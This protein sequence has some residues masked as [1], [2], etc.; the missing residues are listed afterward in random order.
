MYSS[1]QSSGN[2]GYLSS[3]NPSSALP[4]PPAAYS[5]VN[6]TSSSYFTSASSS[7]IPPPPPTQ[8]LPSSAP[9]SL[10]H[11]LLHSNQQ[12]TSLSSSSEQYH[13]SRSASGASSQRPRRTSEGVGFR[14]ITRGASDLRPVVN[15]VPPERRL[16]P[17]NGGSISPL[18]ALTTHL[19][20]TYRLINPN[21][22]YELSLNPRRVLTKPSRPAGNNGM[23]NEDSDYILYVNDILGGGS[24][25]DSNED[26]ADTQGRKGT[27]GHKYLI[28][29]VL[30]QGTFGQVVK[31]QDMKNHEV[32]AVK[33][34]KNKQAYFSQ[35]MM[36]VTILELL[37]NTWDPDNKHHILR[38]KDTFIHHNH[39]CLVFELLSSNLY[40]LIKQNSFRGLSTSLVRV[41]TN[42]L[43]DALTVL[44][45]ARLIHCD[46]KPENILLNSLSSPEIKVIDFGSACHERQTVYTYIQSRF[47]RSPEVI[48]GLPYSSAIDM[49]SLGCICVELFLGLPLFPGTSEFNQ[50]TRIVEMLGMP[51]TYMLEVGKQTLQFF[52][53]LEDDF[54]GGKVYKLKSL[55]QYSKEHNVNE[56]PS[57]RYFQQ[58][59]LEDI[60]SQYPVMR[61]GMKSADLEKEKHNRIAFIDF[62]KGL[63]HLN[64]HQRWTPQQARLHPFIQGEPLREP[65]VP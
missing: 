28:L 14:R 44:N 24:A 9:N 13:A 35:S 54:N 49:W 39:L 2:T 10:R 11:S 37:N 43:L 5:N 42:Q 57:K 34:V 21:F 1:S 64:P 27:D 33:V 36:E 6:P 56:Q 26:A 15:Q 8:T 45:E 17:I 32:V 47:Y 23:D 46:L 30:G 63:L 12:S 55:E 65:Y 59:K 3:A 29:D 16:D 7:G 61:K 41:F 40:E 52:D 4:P 51:P 60:I 19:A 18:K 22:R 25:G 53:V 20:S 50:I 58:D 38:M 62:V 48:L 31:C